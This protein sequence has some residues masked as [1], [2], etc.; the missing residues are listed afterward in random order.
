[1]QIF[2]KVGDLRAWLSEPVSG[3]SLAVVRILFGA[4]LVWDYFRYMDGN[5]ILGA[6]VLIPV[7]FPYFGLDFLKPLPEPWIYVAWGVVGVSAALVM[8]GL[9]F[10]V[11]IVVFIVSFGYFFLLDRVQYLNHNYMVLLYAALLAVSPANRVWSLDAL[12]GLTGRAERIPRWPVFAIRLQTEIILIFAGLVKITD[13]WLRGQ[14]LLMW[15]PA[16]KD[17]VFYGALFEN[18]L[19][20]VAVSWAVVALHLIGAPLLLYRRTR[21]ALFVV[22]VFFH[23]SNAAL[24]NIGIFP[25]LTIAVTLI[26]F[27]PDWPS[28]VWRW[29][30]AR[31]GPESPPPASG[32]GESARATRPIG[33]GLSLFLA[34][35]FAVQLIL[36]L[37]QAMFPNLVGWTGDGHRFSWRMR[38][39][40]RH[41]EGGYLAVNPETGERYLFDPVDFLGPRSAKYVMTRADISRDFAIWLEGRLKTHAGWPSARIYPRYTVAFNGRPAQAFLDPNVDL[42]ETERNLFGPDPWI[43]PLETRAATDKLPGWF[44]PLPLQKP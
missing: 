39:Y 21:L 43:V 23:V 3:Q 14:P 38:V 18:D 25:W 29:L 5:R 11:A 8:L 36:P 35:W 2:G 12:L 30:R 27:D 26:F 31:P 20:V 19:F 24:F 28:Q 15:L 42:T 9:F 22:Y 4:I 16:N 32:I 7:Q 17:T 37:R 34:A 40:S 1:M 41:A 33:A 44:P 13:D 6:Y 10:R